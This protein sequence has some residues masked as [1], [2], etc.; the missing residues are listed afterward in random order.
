MSDLDGVYRYVRHDRIQEFAENGWVFVCELSG[1]HAQWSVLM[2]WRG[3]E[4][5]P[6]GYHFGDGN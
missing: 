1:H 6:D 5:R 3:D 4:P 2:K